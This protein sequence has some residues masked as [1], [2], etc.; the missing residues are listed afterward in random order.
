MITKEYRQ[1][2][3]RKKPGYATE[4]MRRWRA[5][6][7]EKTK[8]LNKKW[9][10]ANP[11]KVKAS[12][13]TESHKKSIRKHTL[14]KKYGI[15]LEEYDYLFSLQAG[16]CAI[17]LLPETMKNQHGL[18]KM[19]VDHD[20]ATGRIRS[21]LCGHCNLAVGNVREDVKIVERLMEYIKKHTEYE[22]PKD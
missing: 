13:Q 20:H 7:P 3:N 9:R 16:V 21:L 8:A 12:R 15:T 18:K 1:A 2:W 22:E 5:K 14:K 6:Y 19:A 11:E 4:V 17:C 10:D